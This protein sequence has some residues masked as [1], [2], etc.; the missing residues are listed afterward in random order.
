[1]EGERKIER[2]EVGSVG[3][4]RRIKEGGGKEREMEERGLK[5]GQKKGGAERK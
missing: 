4:N 2:G 5:E 1:M 3:M